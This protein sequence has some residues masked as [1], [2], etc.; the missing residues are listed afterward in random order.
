MAAL[1]L[2]VV[3]WNLKGDLLAPRLR[4]PPAAGNSHLD[5]AVR[6]FPSRYTAER[7]TPALVGGPTKL[8]R[9]QHRRVD[10]SGFTRWFD[11]QPRFVYGWT[12]PDSIFGL[13]QRWRVVRDSLAEY[14]ELP[15]GAA[16]FDLALLDTGGSRHLI[17]S[18]DSQGIG[19]S[20]NR[21]VSLDEAGNRSWTY[22]PPERGVN[23]FAILHGTKGPYGVAVTMGGET[24]IVALDGAG[25]ELWTKPKLYV[26]YEVHTH[27]ALPGWLLEVGGNSTLFHHSRAGIQ[28]EWT[29][30]GRDYY[31]SKGMLFPDEE[32]RPAVVAA[33]TVHSAKEPVLVRID[34]LGKEVWRVR[35]RSALEA[36]ALLEPEGSPRLLAATTRGGHLILVDEAGVLR[37]RGDLPNDRPGL[38]MATYGLSAGEFA[39][40][41]WAIAVR[42]LW[43]AYVYELDLSALDGPSAERPSRK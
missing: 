10:F 38:N 6:W 30:D 39:P 20:P 34:H 16:T 27:P 29:D 18:I 22:K 2:G 40:G 7:L 21:V 33:A 12:M 15:V 3:L 19:V 23:D 8:D 41:R 28:F 37:W 9:Q 1:L 43:G 36:L 24:G 42:L 32:N 35:P 11:A 5:E 14:E 31:A 13:P 4:R 26:S 17:A 25:V